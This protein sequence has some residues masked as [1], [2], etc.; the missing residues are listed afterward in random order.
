[1]MGMIITMNN[2]TLRV[3]AF[4]LKK[5]LPVGK[6]S[7]AVEVFITH[8]LLNLPWTLIMK[9][10]SS[11]GVHHCI[12]QSQAVVHCYMATE[13]LASLRKSGSKLMIQRTA[14]PD[15]SND[16]FD[17]DLQASLTQIVEPGTYLDYHD[18]SV[19]LSILRS[20]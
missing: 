12:A 6:S 14:V 4:V 18:L 10:S 13:Q 17:D 5:I 20:T 3:I 16:L 8:S 9:Y 2:N 19:S 15:A 7:K 1:M 11:A